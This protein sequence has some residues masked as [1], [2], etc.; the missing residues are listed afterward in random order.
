SPP[1]AWRKRL[2]IISAL[3]VADPVGAGKPR[4]QA[5]ASAVDLSEV[6]LALAHSRCN[7]EALPRCSRVVMS[8]STHA[9]CNSIATAGEELD[10]ARECLAGDGDGDRP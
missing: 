1:S 9:T 5:S 6:S 10:L 3:R 8:L 4:S 7:T 2:E